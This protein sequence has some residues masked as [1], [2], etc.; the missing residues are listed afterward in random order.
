VRAGPAPA[1][2]RGSV[3]LAL[4]LFVWVTTIATIALLDVAAYL[5]AA[6]RAQSLADAAALAAV[7]ADA[8]VPPR[9]DPHRQASSVVAAGAGRLERCDC[10]AGSGRATAQVSVAVPGLVVPRLG[11]GRVLA[12]SDAVL[13][14][15]AAPRAAPAVAV[16]ARDPPPRAAPPVPR[17]HGASA[18]G[19]RPAAPGPLRAHVPTRTCTLPAGRSFGWGRAPAQVPARRRPSRQGADVEQARAAGAPPADAHHGGDEPPAV[20]FAYDPEVRA[21]RASVVGFLLDAARRRPV[22]RAVLSGLTVLLF[23]GGAGTFAY[24]FFTDL[25]TDRVVQQQLADQYGRIEAGSVEEWQQTVSA[26]Q[27]LT[28]IVIPALDVET[29]VVAGTSPA[30]LR[31]G[32]GHYPD[33]PL[34]GQVGNVGIAGH[35]TTYG[36]PFNRMDELREGDEVWLLTPVGDHRYV[37]AAPPSGGDCQLFA[38]A[39][40]APEGTATCITHPRDW[41]V[42]APSDDALLTLTSCHPKGSAAQRIVARAVLAESLPPGT[43]ETEHGSDETSDPGGDPD[44][45]DEV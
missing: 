15:P 2:Q 30:A 33:T 3:S 10:V 13:A 4:P 27:P 42:V 20:G 39:P 23:L 35:R 21:R 25:Y 45:T 22:G 24:P 44:E 36:R 34:P 32:A 7:S 8:A 31:A 19:G 28:K 6:S 18:R 38:G 40:G 16:P 43:W 41:S 1:D 11:A 37:V 14:P 26:G 29:L 12:T 9:G 5:V 17:R